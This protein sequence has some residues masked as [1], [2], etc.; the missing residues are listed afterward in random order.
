MIFELWLDLSHEV[1]EILKKD[2]FRVLLPII[3]INVPL[4]FT[5]ENGSSKFLF[6]ESYASTYI[7][8]YMYVLFNWTSIFFFVIVVLCGCE[9]SL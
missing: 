6:I 2:K 1:L 3:G 8:I 5:S 7:Y 9:D 4:I